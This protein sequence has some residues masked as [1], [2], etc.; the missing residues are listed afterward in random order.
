MLEIFDSVLIVIILSILILNCPQSEVRVFQQDSLN[1]PDLN[2]LTRL[3]RSV[4]IVAASML[5]VAALFM[6][7]SVTTQSGTSF[8]AAMA[9]CNGSGESH[10]DNTQEPNVENAVTN[11]PSTQLVGQS[12]T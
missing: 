5:G 1:T 4:K 6:A 2:T 3:N 11:L 12:S 7:V 10:A 8:Q 9:V